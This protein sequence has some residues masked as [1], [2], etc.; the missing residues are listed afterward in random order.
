MASDRLIDIDV[1]IFGKTG[2]GKSST[3]NA[4]L[5]EKGFE[6]SDSAKPHTLASAYKIVIHGNKRIKIA[7]TPGLQNRNTAEEIE[8]ISEQLP[9]AMSFFPNGIH[10]MLLVVKYG[11]RFTEEEINTVEILKACFGE[12]FLR[13]RVII[14]V[15][16][17]DNFD[18]E[19]EEDNLSF[20][21]WWRQ[22]SGEFKK[23][24]DECNERIVLF[25]NNGRQYQDKREQA[26][27]KLLE[28]I[29]NLMV[30]SENIRYTND[31]FTKCFLERK[32]LLLELKLP[33]LCMMFRDKIIELEGKIKIHYKEN[34]MSKEEQT[35]LID[36]C[37]ELLKEIHEES[38]GTDSFDDFK[39]KVEE[40]HKEIKKIDT[41]NPIREQLTQSVN[42]MQNLINPPVSFAN[43]M[44]IIAGVS[45]ASAFG[46]AAVAFF[47]PAIVL[48][49]VGVAVADTVM[50]AGTAGI[51][52]AA[53][54][55]VG[56][57]GVTAVA[58][59]TALGLTSGRAGKTTDNNTREEETDSITAQDAIEDNKK[60][61]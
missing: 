15:T 1:I 61:L 19:H 2:N 55:A 28:M 20:D 35:E 56:A 40:L 7:D 21:S 37:A 59:M 13:D 10:V 45:I 8:N 12:D 3:G 31:D 52:T 27:A 49:A 46:A 29:T 34:T 36:Q 24:I 14:V 16:F 23:L 44:R 47:S 18:T 22:P 25:Y 11:N 4:I 26:V 6:A 60:Q 32:R 42:I 50:A 33:Q 9:M 17:G 30:K 58:G 43:V 51:A 48:G 38:K 5:G 57:A 53:L 39:K 54:S 41:K